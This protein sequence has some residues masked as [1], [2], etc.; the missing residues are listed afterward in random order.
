M[1]RYLLDKS[2]TSHEQ[3]VPID[4]EDLQAFAQQVKADYLA[5]EAREKAEI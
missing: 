4:P 5:L 1:G 2:V 3:D